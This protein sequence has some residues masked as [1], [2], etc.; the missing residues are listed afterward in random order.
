[1]QF[2]LG[3]DFAKATLAALAYFRLA[4]AALES[5]RAAPAR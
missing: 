2:H 3:D 5:R 1:M 4:A